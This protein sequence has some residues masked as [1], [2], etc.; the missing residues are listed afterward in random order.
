MKKGS[1]AIVPLIIGVVVAVLIGVALFPAVWNSVD[2]DTCATT[3]ATGGCGTG[4]TWTNQ[5]PYSSTT[6][7]MMDLAPVFIAL[8]IGLVGVVLIYKTMGNK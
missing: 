8:A 7:A 5:T 6:T 2:Y 3:N 1:L 4:A